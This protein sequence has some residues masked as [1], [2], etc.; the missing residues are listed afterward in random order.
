MWGLQ[1]ASACPTI[2]VSG[3]VLPLSWS[4]PTLALVGPMGVSCDYHG[5]AGADV[6]RR[7]P[8]AD[9]RGPRRGSGPEGVRS[10][11]S[12][13]PAIATPSGDPA[14]GGGVAGHGGGGAPAHLSGAAGLHAGDLDDREAVARTQLLPRPGARADAEPPAAADDARE[15]RG[16]AGG[17]GEAAAPHDHLAG[18]AHATGH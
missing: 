15:A 16:D 12:A 6:P 18:S 1:P 2:V 17:L 8:P 3:W 9:A 7:P 11:R 4:R 13:G 14:R 10:T 5:V